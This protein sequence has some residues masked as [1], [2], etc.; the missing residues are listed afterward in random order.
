MR[1]GEFASIIA[2]V[3]FTRFALRIITTIAILRHQEPIQWLIRMPIIIT[4]FKIEGLQVFESG[5]RSPVS[6]RLVDSPM[7]SLLLVY[8]HASKR[9]PK[10]AAET[11]STAEMPILAGPSPIFAMPLVMIGFVWRGSPCILG[12]IGPSPCRHPPIPR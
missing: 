11:L 3:N 5:R 6:L 10:P 7:V 8:I 9:P 2:S 4:S 12:T 1:I